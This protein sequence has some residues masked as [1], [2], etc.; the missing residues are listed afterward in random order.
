MERYAAPHLLDEQIDAVMK[1]L[2]G[3]LE[4][5]YST[6]FL[7]VSPAAMISFP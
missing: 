6:R 3:D 2:A 5:R 1:C 7:T 4:D